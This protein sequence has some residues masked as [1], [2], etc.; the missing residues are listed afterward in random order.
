MFPDVFQQ[1]FPSSNPSDESLPD[2]D[3]SEESRKE[4]DF[5]NAFFFKESWLSVVIQRTSSRAEGGAASRRLVANGAQSDATEG[6]PEVR[7]LCLVAMARRH[8]H[9]QRLVRQKIRFRRL[10]SSSRSTRST[11][12]RGRIRTDGASPRQLLQRR[13]RPVATR[14]DCLPF[15]KREPESRERLNRTGIKL[16]K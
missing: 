4:S 6:E 3:V 10:G 16:E 13:N 11:H 2:E 14:I 7:A 15:T 1:S 8:H 5:R 12:L 9:Q